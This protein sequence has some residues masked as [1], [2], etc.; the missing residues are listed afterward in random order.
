MPA[1]KY[2][3]VNTSGKRV[4]GVLYAENE[5]DLQQNLRNMH[6]YLIEARE[7]RPSKE[8]RLWKKIKRKDL[9]TFTVHLQTIVSAGISIIQ[10]L[11][12]LI[13]QTSNQNFK[14]VLEDVQAAIQSGS[15][16]SDAMERHPKAFSSLFVSVVRAGEA[17]GNLDSV[18]RDLISFLEWQEEIISSIR[19][20]T[21]YPIIV[22]TAV[23]GL[24][25]LL[26]T[27][28]FPR[29]SIIFEKANVP[30]PLPTR[31]VMG[32]SHLLTHDW[33]IL[34]G[35]V[36]LIILLFRIFVKTDTGRHV[37]DA[38]K[39][40]I[41][42]FGKLILKINL[43]RFSHYLGTLIRAGID[44]T[45]SLRIVENVIGNVVISD[46]VRIV[47]AR[48][49]AGEFMSDTLREYPQFPPLV[50]RMISIGESSGNLEET[51][52]K[53][54][55]YYDR[56]V[57]VTIKKVFAVFEPLVIVFLAS[58]V[59]LMALSMFLPLYQMMGVIAK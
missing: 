19:Q 11:G 26:M 34:I 12:D 42:V 45:Q 8:I 39:L 15:S 40:R 10:G 21:I 29:F 48:V 22:L 3:A 55:A 28:V 35:A 54:S 31:I 25:I 6:L 30:L 14:K 52:G 56:E 53:V 49:Q 5:R 36:F 23:T 33:P 1:F 46:I 57:P 24:V 2:R 59:L 38:L 50:V 17:S 16:L 13:E 41:P 4:S 20:A 18:L 47:R 32:V 37:V 44:I 9:L 7:T 51:L 58:I 27:F 43:S